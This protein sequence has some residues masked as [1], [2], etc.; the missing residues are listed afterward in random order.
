MQVLR[1]RRAI[2]IAPQTLWRP[3]T[4]SGRSDG[5]RDPKLDGEVARQLGRRGHRSLDLRPPIRRQLAVGKRCD[6]PVA[7][8]RHA[9]GYALAGRSDCSPVV[10]V[11]PSRSSA[12]SWSP[13]R[14][15][16][17]SAVV[18]RDRADP[19]RRPAAQL[20][21]RT[22]ND[23]PTGCDCCAADDSAGRAQHQR[24]DAESPGRSCS[25]VETFVS[26]RPGQTTACRP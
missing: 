13:R 7:D 23:R 21:H 24:R 3:D 11:A 20:R 8:P 19:H 1:A 10:T 5:R 18:D 6:V 4:G 17:S 26:S 25:G 16:A 22:R 9:G 15:T 12:G 14:P 2:G